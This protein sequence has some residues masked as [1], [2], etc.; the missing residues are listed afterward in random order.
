MLR[1]L[2]EWALSF[3]DKPYGVWVMAAISFADSSFLPLVPDVLLAPMVLGR[4]AKAYY[5]AII[6]TLASVAGA[7]LGYA[8]GAFLWDTLGQWL[9]RFYHL[10]SKMEDFRALYAQYGAWVILLKGFTPI[11]YKLVTIV[12]GFAG[13]NFIA[14]IVL[15]LLTRGARFL[16]LAWILVRYGEQV[17]GALDRHLAVIVTALLI[18]LVGGIVVALYLV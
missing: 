3:A 7:V 13:Y 2:Y 12:S 9:I 17:R 8:V 14:F 11:P 16:A 4:P 6:C 5:Y 1:R 18:L 15:S 10:E